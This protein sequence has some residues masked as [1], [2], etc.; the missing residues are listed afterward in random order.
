[1]YRRIAA[2]FVF[3][4]TLSACGPGDK[5]SGGA[6]AGESGGWTLVEEGRIGSDEAVD[7]VAFGQIVGLAVDGLNRVWVADGQQQEIRVFDW[8]G[9]LVRTVGR[10]GAGP[11]EF[12]NLAGM[13][14]GPDGKLW[15]VDGGNER[16]AVYDTAGALVTTHRR[17]ANY[18]MI[19]WPGSIDQQGRV[20][21]MTMSAEGGMRELIVRYGPGAQPLDTFA[22]PAFEEQKFTLEIND[23]PRRSRTDMNVPFS[24][25][26]EWRVDPRGHVWI[27][28]TDRYRVERH[29]FGGGEPEVVAE[30]EM[31]PVPVTREARDKALEGYRTFQEKGGKV[32]LSRI[33]D[34]YPALQAFFFDDRGRLW[35]MPILGP[36]R[37]ALDVFDPEGRFVARMTPPAPVVSMPAPAI[38]GGRMAALTHDEDGVPS[39]VLMRIQEGS[40]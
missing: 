37:S 36:G 8:S 16:Y 24:P 12:G 22:L 32:D 9:K 18:L 2:P 30:R 26:Q 39:V 4:A 38:R 27:S 6:P 13:A 11:E 34:T 33:P 3:C 5:P 31:A 23:G 28:R 7:G 40:K 15:V 10:K 19:P 35:V 25:S 1:M 21:D 29:P 14:W 20:Y 17:R